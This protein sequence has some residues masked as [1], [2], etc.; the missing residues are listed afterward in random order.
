MGFFT[1]EWLWN[2]GTFNIL[3]LLSLL[4]F[5]NGILFFPAS[6]IILITGGILVALYNVNFLLVFSL[7]VFSNF[8]GNYALYWISLNWGEDAARRFLPVGKKKLDENI[9]A[10]SYLFKKYGAFIVFAGRNLPVL[11]SV[12]SIPAGVARMPG[13]KYSFYT[14]LGICTW[15]LLFMW[16]GISFGSN[17]E[18]FIDKFEYFAVGVTSVL[19]GGVWCFYRFYLDDVLERARAE[20]LKHNP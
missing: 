4:S 10:T 3:A 17:Y 20:A 9:L 11:H 16:V 19:L 5:T 14:L 7:L 8:L 13:W 18:Y 15:S 12:V 6:Q 2:L 1:F